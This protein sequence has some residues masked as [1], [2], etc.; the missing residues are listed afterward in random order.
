[1]AP[2]LTSSAPDA[3]MPG[4]G[5]LCGWLGRDRGNAAVRS[6]PKATVRRKVKCDTA[7]G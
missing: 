5:H 2:G 1:M 3:T 7:I 4:A 6:V